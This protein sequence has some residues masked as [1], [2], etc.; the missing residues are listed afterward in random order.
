MKLNE[1]Q[2]NEGSRKAKKRVGRGMGS[3]TGKTSA[4]G[5]KGQKSRSGVSIKGFEGGQMPLHRRLPKR[6]FNNIFRKDV[7]VVRLDFL[8]KA[9][10]EKKIDPKK[11]IT[12]D[13]LIAAGV[14]DRKADLY[15]L[16]ANKTEKFA[17]KVDIQ[18]D[19][20]SASALKIIEAVGGKVSAPAK[21][22]EKKAE[23]PKKKAAAK[24]E[25]KSS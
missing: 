18:A 24:K 2:F 15:K 7:S 11:A 9:I 6:G 23:A 14:L 17:H 4:R 20:A 22:D 19:A 8:S 25:D 3:G 5:M 1:L 12:K 16:L 21:A 10:D 13:V